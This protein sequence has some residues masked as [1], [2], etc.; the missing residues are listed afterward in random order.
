MQTYS[1]SGSQDPISSE[2]RQV[3][4]WSLHEKPSRMVWLQIFGIPIFLLAAALFVYLAFKVGRWPADFRFGLPEVGLSLFGMAVTIVLHELVHG[5]TMRVFGARPLYG[6]LWKQ[7]AFY[8]TSPGYGFRRNSYLMIALAPLVVL[9]LLAVLGMAL[10]PGTGWVA[11]FALCAVINGSGASGDLWMAGIVI[12][13]P[14]SAYVVDE[15]DGMR[16][17][18]RSS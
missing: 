9:S 16:I 6:V 8:A 10:L 4:Y 18:L 1:L 11:L 5:L 15:R 17:L 13:Y 3:L 2:Y 14:R 7:A 12:R